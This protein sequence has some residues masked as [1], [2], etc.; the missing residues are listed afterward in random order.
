VIVG[1][2]QVCTYEDPYGLSD[3]KVFVFCFGCYADGKA[4]SPM[5]DTTRGKVSKTDFWPWVQLVEND[6]GILQ[7][8]LDEQNQCA[9]IHEKK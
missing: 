2:Q 5:V 1:A 9:S 7:K 3:V 8:L 4:K 6:T